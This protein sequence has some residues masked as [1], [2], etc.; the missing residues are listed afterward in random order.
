MINEFENKKIF[1]SGGT[2]GIGY[3]IAKNFRKKS[4]NLCFGKKK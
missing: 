1:V 3:E 4:E 2:N